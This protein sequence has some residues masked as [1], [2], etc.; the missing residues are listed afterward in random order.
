MILRLTSF[1]FFFLQ[2]SLSGFALQDSVS[3]KDSSAAQ[4]DSLNDSKFQ[5]LIK[6]SNEMR[7]LDSLQK[8]ELQKKIDQLRE[9]N[10][11]EKRRLEFELSQL[12]SK[13]S[14]RRVVE[15]RQIDSLKNTLV[16]YPVVPFADTLL[17]IYIKSGSSTP[18]ER[19]TNFAR[20]VQALYKDD[21][22]DVDSILLDE[23]DYTVDI[24][25]GDVIITSISDMD[26]QW[27]GRSKL[28]IAKD[29]QKRIKEAI[30]KEREERSFMK[31][32]SRTGLVLLITSLIGL[33]IFGIGKLYRYA[34]RLIIAQK[35]KRI[36]D[37]T[38]KDY[39]LVSSK[40]GLRLVLSALNFL[41]WALI[42]LLLFLTLPLVFS[43][44]PFTQSWAERLFSMVWA[45]FRSLFVA[46]WNYFPN[47]I[48]ILVIYFVMKYFIRMV[49][50]IFGEIDNGK[51]EINGFHRDWAM[52]TFSIVKFLLYAFML[53]LI[54]PLLPGSDSNI[55]KGVSV[56]IGILF[57]LGSSSA[58]ANMV[59]GLVI[60]YM[61]PFKIGDKIKTGGVTGTVIEKTLLV[62]RLRTILNEEITIPN[63]A[64]L[65]GNTTNYSTFSETGIIVHVSVSIGY[66]VPWKKVHDA[67]LEAA[68]KID[69]ILKDPAPFVL[70]TSLDDFYVS[71]VLNVFVS[72]PGL[73]DDVKSQMNQHI[74]D[75]FAE[76]KIEIMSPHYQAKRDG[77]E[78]TIP[79]MDA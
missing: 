57:S 51:L 54:F 69:V 20:K 47:L 32:L 66:D 56:F 38:I 11:F 18:K 44:F 55:F 12:A 58:I 8:V 26:A 1:I 75:V 59:A 70:Q 52:P 76:K 7:I 37:L 41:K 74:Q 15:K 17:T 23:S 67:L 64:I 48:T 43:V 2:F 45:P 5:D 27:E 14:L 31:M 25:V 35:N 9:T 78:S 40:Q 30:I 39:T 42:F 4:T 63:S 24:V 77:S 72:Q 28:E 6:E 73:E 60:T 50:Y 65:S 22:L 71:Y 29:Y 34:E 3:K 49:K 16:G 68:L 36:K 19:A 13:D 10:S 21:F 53:I 79:D 61:R 33:L 46:I 62:T